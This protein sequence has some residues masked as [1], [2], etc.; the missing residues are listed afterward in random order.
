M[1]A[2][3]I[4]T[5]LQPCTHIRMSCAHYNKGQGAGAR[6]IAHAQKDTIR[7]ACAHE[8]TG[9][10]ARLRAYAVREQVVARKE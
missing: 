5:T 10:Q 2:G 1:P 6:R 4:S 7:H 9:T 3:R 8:L